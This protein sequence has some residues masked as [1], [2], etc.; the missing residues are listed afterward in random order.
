MY[1]DVQPV[2]SVLQQYKL[3]LYG[4]IKTAQHSNELLHSKTVI[5]TLA[6]GR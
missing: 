1:T 6:V 5:G 4:S 2:I 3:T